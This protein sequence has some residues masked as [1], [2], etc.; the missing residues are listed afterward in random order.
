MTVTT[1]IRRGAI[2]ATITLAVISG[3]ARPAAAEAPVPADP[4]VVARTKLLDGSDALKRG[5]FKDALARF[6]EAYDLVP[7]P[8]IH[9]NF[10]L[11]YRGLGRPAEAIDAFERF[12]ADA[13]DAS[14]DLRANAERFRSELARQV[15][16]VVLTCAVEGAEISVDG[17]SYGVTP[18]RAPLRLD[19]GPHQIVV[20]KAPSAPFT[21]KVELAVGQ[22]L[23]VEVVLAQ[24]GEPRE[25][26]SPGP[27]PVLVPAAPQPGAPPPAA[28]EPPR[29]H[30]S[31]KWKA[32]W[33]VAAVGVALV[34]YGVAQRM[35]ANATFREF[36]GAMGPFG[37]C[38]ADDRVRDHGGGSCPG[39]LSD[40]NSAAT[41]AIV[42]FVVGGAFAAGGAALLA[43]TWNETK[44]PP[45]LPGFACAPEVARP[46]FTCAIRF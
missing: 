30:H 11:A 37:P 12:L 14:P 19:P 44:E 18:P 42:G 34:G 45:V 38:D 20:E 26:S 46:G 4:R 40:G 6:R 17:R 27:A 10:G 1:A 41:K 22:R 29:P 21:R 2:L 8:K 23:T 16:T 32:G 33:G 5:D 13:N 35:S 7:S 31:W 39:L 15:G 36:N 9:Y 43:L 28:D 25:T 24:E 3:S